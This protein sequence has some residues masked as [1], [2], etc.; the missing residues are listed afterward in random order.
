MDISLFERMVNNNMQCATLTTQYRMRP[1]IASLLRT[2]IYRDLIDDDSVKKYPNIV[3][4]SKNL[5]F[6][7]HTEPELDVSVP[8]GALIFSITFSIT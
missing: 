4:L 1:E 5:Y 8:I 2:T 3:G 6:I 7:N